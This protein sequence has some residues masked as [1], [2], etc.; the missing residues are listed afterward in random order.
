MT[1]SSPILPSVV[2]EENYKQNR[3]QVFNRV[4]EW[5]GG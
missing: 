3:K 1:S 5:V 4:G 2:E